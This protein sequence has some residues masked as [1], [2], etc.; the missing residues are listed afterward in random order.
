[1]ASGNEARQR[2][3]WAQD[4]PQENQT[5]KHGKGMLMVLGI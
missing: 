1:M 5:L 2:K 4:M 3:C